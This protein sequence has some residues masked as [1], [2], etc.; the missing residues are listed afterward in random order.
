MQ[1]H[2]HDFE[3]KL[4]VSGNQAVADKI[5]SWVKY[6]D[7]CDYGFQKDSRGDFTLAYEMDA[8]LYLLV[9]VSDKGFIVSSYTKTKLSEIWEFVVKKGKKETKEREQIAVMK[10]FWRHLLRNT[11]RKIEKANCII[12]YNKII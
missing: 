12:K 5:K 8:N 10:C 2:G 4:G 3:R 6:G 9:V 1:N 7:W 11:K